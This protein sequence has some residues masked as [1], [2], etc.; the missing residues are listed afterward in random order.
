MTTS[1]HQ[2]RLLEGR[3]WL[4]LVVAIVGVLFGLYRE[5]GATMRVTLMFALTTCLSI[6]A[7]VSV[8]RWYGLRYTATALP[9]FVLLMAAGIV[10]PATWLTS[11]PPGTG[12]QAKRPL[13]TGLVTALLLAVLAA[14]NVI[15]ARADAQR[16]LDWRGVAHF[17]DEIALDNEPILMGN[18]WPEICL[19]YYLRDLDRRARFINLWESSARG[20]EVVERTPR[21]WLLTAGFR[22]TNEVRGWMHRFQPVLKKREEEMAL[23]FFPD[24]PTLLETRFAAGKG[25]VF[26]REFEATGRRFDFGGAELLLQGRGWSYPETNRGGV[27]YQWAMGPVVELGLPLEK[28]RPAWIRLRALPFQYPEAPPQILELRL[29]EKAI[30]TV[31]LVGGWTQHE[32]RVPP[33]AWSSGANILF[34]TFSRSTAPAQVVPGS[35]DQRPLSAAFDFLELVVDEELME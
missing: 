10:F 29:N 13:A 14:P 33:A 34:L 24:F 30:A 11:R 8:E 20:E 17:F 7:L 23:F 32:F 5:P 31:E 21:G 16:K 6:A 27:G 18:T 19:G 3:S 4:L 28:P 1:G 12:W 9:A 15:A 26:E 25:G 22:K 35:H 2:S